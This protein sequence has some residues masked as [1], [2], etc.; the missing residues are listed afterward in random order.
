MAKKAKK[1]KKAISLEV[2]LRSEYKDKGDIL[3]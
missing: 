3:D 1:P 2:I